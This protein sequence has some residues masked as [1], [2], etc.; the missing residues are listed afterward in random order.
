MQLVLEVSGP[1]VAQNI[2]RHLAVEPRHAID[3]L[4]EVAGEHRH[5]E[6]LVRVVGVGLAEVDELLPGDAQHV[7]IVRHV[8]ADHRLGEGVVARGHRRVGREERRRADDFER[9]GERQ[10]LVVHHLADALDADECGMALVAVEHLVLDAQRADAADA[11]Q[12]LL[13]EA[14]LPVAA[15]EVVGDLTVLVEVGLEIG[16][17][18]VEV[19]AAHLTAPYAGR[20]RAARERHGDRHPVAA[21]VAHGR[22]GQLVEVLRLVGRLLRTLGREP[23]REV[24]E[25]V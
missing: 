24:S 13:L 14:V 5:G 10:F 11:E 1:D 7:G 21:G 17:E 23:L 3:L 6:L 16:V 22:Y 19:R 2:L 25:A 15:V 12:D 9:F 8:L 20:E 18:Q 4:R